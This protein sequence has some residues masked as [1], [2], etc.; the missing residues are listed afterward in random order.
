MV[1]LIVLS[2]CLKYFAL[3]APYVCYHIFSS[4]EP[5]ADQGSQGELIVY[6]SVRC[7]SV[8]RLQFQRS[9]SLKLLG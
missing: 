3:L 9:S 6:Q 1:V 5:K 8:R 7:P 2:W 4:P